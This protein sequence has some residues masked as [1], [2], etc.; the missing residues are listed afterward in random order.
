[1]KFNEAVLKGLNINF[2]GAID[3]FVYA[4]FGYN[5]FDLCGGNVRF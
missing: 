5:I 4:P 1:M 2:S 3:L